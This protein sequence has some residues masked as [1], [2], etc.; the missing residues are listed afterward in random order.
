MDGFDGADEFVRAAQQQDDLVVGRPQ[1]GNTVDLIG[2]FDGV[3]FDVAHAAG[4]GGGEGKGCA[5]QGC[6]KGFDGLSE[7]FGFPLLGWWMG[8]QTAFSVLAAPKLCFQTAFRFGTIMQSL[9]NAE[10]KTLQ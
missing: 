7:H 3:A 1:I 8:F 9:S 6:G 10:E 5:E 2:D 4:V